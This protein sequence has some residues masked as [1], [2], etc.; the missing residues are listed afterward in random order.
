[1]INIQDKKDCV[2]CK[3]CQQRCPQKC[4]SFYTDEQGFGYPKVDIERCINCRLCEVVCPVIHQKEQQE[5]QQSYAAWNNNEEVRIKSSS[6]GIFLALASK[7]IEQGGVVFGAKF[8]EK[9]NVVHGYTETLRG[10]EFFQGSK[11][12]QSNIGNM[13][14]YA[15]KF[16]KEGR[17]VLFSG[18]PCQIAGLK[19]FLRMEYEKLITVDVACHG[20]PSPK[21]WVDYL[22]SIIRKKYAEC[23]KNKDSKTINDISCITGISFR[24]KRNG[25]DQYGFNVRF[26]MPDISCDEKE[27]YQPSSQNDFMKGFLK[28]LYLRPSCYKCPAKCGK[29]HSDITLADFWRVKELYPQVYDNR[30]VSLLM[31]NTPKGNRLIEASNLQKIPVDYKISLSGNPALIKSAD[32]PDIYAKFWQLYNKNGIDAL[33]DILSKIEPSIITRVINK[34][35]RQLSVK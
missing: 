25:W 17:Y 10:I 16:L 2:G 32:E 14:F 27:N 11:Y 12:V 4:I 13:F 1:M 5:P 7:V 8:N 26:S 15:E 29:S 20:V 33:D 3:A 34:I 28:D 18:T 19:L 30:G 24:D 35:K 21:V 23:D 9:W 6:G 31:S 22:N